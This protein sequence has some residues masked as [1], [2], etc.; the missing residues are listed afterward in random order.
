M[1]N[2]TLEPKYNI[3]FAVQMCIFLVIRCLILFLTLLSKIS[4]VA[5]TNRSVQ[6][7]LWNKNYLLLA[8]L[9]LLARDPKFKINCQH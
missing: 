1:I 5:F 2:Y 3:C 8:I 7:L 4:C 9:L 6:L